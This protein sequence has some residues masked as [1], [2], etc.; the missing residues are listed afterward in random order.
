MTVSPLIIPDPRISVVAGVRVST[1]AQADKYGPARQRE[2]IIREA[3]RVG[4]S[5][6]HWVEEAISGTDHDRA[7]ENQYYALARRFP[8]LNFMFS[9]PNRIGRHI[10]V[11][12]GIARTIH[13]LGGTVHIAGL[14]NL[15]QRQT[16]KYF[17]RDAVDAES[18]HADI[19]DR[20]QRGK[21]DKA[22]QNRWPHGT[23]PYGYRLRRDERG[24][25]VTIEP[26]P[27]TAPY[28]QN[29]FELALNGMG[30]GL[31]AVEM[32]RAGAPSA[33]NGKW[34]HRGVLYILHNEAYSGRRVFE[35]LDGR[36]AIVTFEGLITP[37]QFEKVR[38]MVTARQRIR[39]TQ[40]RRAALLAGHVRCAA[41]G[42]SMNTFA[43][44]GNPGS[45]TQ[46]T[47][48]RCRNAHGGRTYVEARGGKV[49]QNKKM[50]RMEQTDLLGWQAFEAAMI[51]P[52]FLASVVE[53]TPVPRPDHGPRI[54]EIRA[55][56]SQI[57]TR[58]VT[59]NLPDEVIAEALSPL[60]R[61]L[62]QLERDS[63][64]PAPEPTPDMTELAQALATYLPTLNT[65]EERRAV[66][67]T[68]KARLFFS[69]QGIEKLQ[70]E[71]LQNA[72]AF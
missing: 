66:L 49:C 69:A 41:C 5:I 22:A 13:D 3:E 17:L 9:H 38:E 43:S 31:I 72:Q 18:D 58:A 64:P 33:R 65:L 50:L 34:T 52:G 55:Q 15:R 29:I 25:S 60:S 45:L 62:A 44:R 51:D 42:G 24:K 28:V 53:R 12:V 71:V 37:A 19:V 63:I 67:A 32:M 6:C 10:E 59:H 27:A 47:Y 1:D 11:T 54:A 21:Y 16:W 40:T 61:E 36:R 2:D 7:A 4:L 8:G 68:W 14:G 48:Y 23:P 30:S 57:L 56:Q 20:L 70:I 26:D 46:Y 35:S 39:P